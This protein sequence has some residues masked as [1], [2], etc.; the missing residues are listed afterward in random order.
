MRG[1][2]KDRIGRGTVHEGAA[3]RARTAAGR[4]VRGAGPD[5][6]PSGLSEAE[7]RARLFRHGPNA[8]P[9]ARPPSLLRIFVRRQIEA[10]HV[11]PGDPVLLE[12][13][14]RVPADIALG[15]TVNLQCDES[16]LTGESTPVKK[17]AAE[18]S[19]AGAPLAERHDMVFAGTALTRGRDHGIV[20]ATGIDTEIGKI[21][22]QISRRSLSVPPL[23][24]RMARFTRNIGFGVGGA[25][26]LLAGIGLYREMP[27]DELF[28]MSVGLAVSAIPEGLPIAISVAPVIA[29]RR[30]AGVGV[31][32]RNMPAVESPGSC[33]LIAPDKTGTLTLNA[34]TVPDIRLPDGA[35]LEYEPAVGMTDGAMPPRFT[36]AKTRSASSS[37][38]RPK[39]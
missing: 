35:A 21:A 30:M 32:V 19:P 11:V 23:L 18:P 22:K 15:E 9:Q 37:R 28:M 31:I 12:A 24:I 38:A 25:V 36:A 7:A 8:L 34:L 27:L 4:R 33:T 10:R 1:R 17:S 20:M 16:L 2:A 13:G 5:T 6:G 3:N 14:G 26:V 29:M 39:A